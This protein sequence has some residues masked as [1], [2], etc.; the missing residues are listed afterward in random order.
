M[1]GACGIALTGGVARR[2][3]VRRGVWLSCLVVARH[4]IALVRGGSAEGECAVRTRMRSVCVA[5]V[6]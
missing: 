4:G 2:A 5:R 3:W 1:R 6:A